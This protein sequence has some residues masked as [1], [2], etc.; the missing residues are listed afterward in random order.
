MHKSVKIFFTVPL[1]IV[2]YGLFP[3][4]LF[5]IF[6]KN[7]D[8]FIKASNLFSLIFFLNQ[9]VVFHSL[10]ILSEESFVKICIIL[11]ERYLVLVCDKET[12]D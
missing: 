9:W 8:R 4:Y 1:L 3:R 7:L 2:L 5:T 11:I 12:L 10:C 6:I